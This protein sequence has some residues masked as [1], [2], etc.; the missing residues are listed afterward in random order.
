MMRPTADFWDYLRRATPARIALGR[1]GD[2]LP[3][4]RVLEFMLAHARARDAVWADLDSASL[5]AELAAWHP[6]LVRSAAPDRATFLQRPDLGRRLA[7]N[8]AQPSRLAPM[9]PRSSSPT[10]F[11]LAPCKSK[12]PASAKCFWRVRFCFC[13][14]GH[15]SPGAGRLGR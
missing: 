13:P 3:T 14:S 1:A 6:V 15:C 5:L 11:P 2:G 4:R 9:T 10:G 7:Q 12:Q 8:S